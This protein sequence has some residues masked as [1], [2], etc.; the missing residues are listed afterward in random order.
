VD[1][2]LTSA[3][4]EI[5]KTFLHSMQ[6]LETNYNLSSLWYSLAEVHLLAGLVHLLVQR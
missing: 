4:T 5:G 3:S 1:Y 6:V 2:K